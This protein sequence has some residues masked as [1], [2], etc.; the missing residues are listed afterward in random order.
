MQ[1]WNNEWQSV[2]KT[3]DDQKE[4][5]HNDQVTRDEEH[6]DSNYQRLSKSF[7][8]GDGKCT[9]RKSPLNDGKRK[10]TTS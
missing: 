4:K 3:I 10:E 8:Q 1:K 5:L 6:I 2:Q 7:R 9:D